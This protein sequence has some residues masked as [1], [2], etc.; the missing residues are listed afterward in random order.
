M[1]AT[2]IPIVQGFSFTASDP[3]PNID[4]L[5]NP[6]KAKD[7]GELQEHILSDGDRLFRLTK[8]GADHPVQTKSLRVDFQGVARGSS[9]ANQQ[10]QLG[11][12]SKYDAGKNES[13]SFTCV[14]VDFACESLPNIK[15]AL[16][17]AHDYSFRMGVVVHVAPA[18]PVTPAPVAAPAAPTT[19]CTNL[20]CGQTMTLGSWMQTGSTQYCE[21]CGTSFVVP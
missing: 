7:W 3:I 12:L 5:K 19:V 21:H 2:P 8:R 15:L 1:A 6:P 9:C 4:K 16:Q 17:R 20:D 13:T 10:A 18:A 11:G 14:H